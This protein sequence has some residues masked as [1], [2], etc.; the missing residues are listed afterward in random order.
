MQALRRKTMGAIIGASM[1]LAP[2][3]AMGVSVD[4]AEVSTAPAMKPIRIDVA[5]AHRLET[6]L[7]SGGEF[8]I[9]TYRTS[10]AGS[11]A[12]SDVLRWDN[13]F[14]YERNDYGIDANDD[15][16]ANLMSFRSI[17]FYGMSSDWTLFGGGLLRLAAESGADQGDGISAGGIAGFI[18]KCSPTLSVGLGIAVLSDIE[19]D[20][21]IAP[22]PIVEWAF[23][24]GWHLHVGATQYG[25][26][27][28]LGGG[29]STMITDSLELTAGAQYERRRFRL[30][31]RV[32]K[33]DEGV[34]EETS[35]PLYLQASW[36]FSEMASIDVFGG[37]AVGGT[38]TIDDEDGD[39]ISE[40][41]F[42]PTGTFG[43]RLNIRF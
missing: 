28:G 27:N 5:Y 42:D 23:A 20:V 32:G 31:E 36:A 38:L 19:D 14:V 22:L 30:D 29:V 12:L 16:D 26:R 24:Q 8:D 18:H 35:I 7:D 39:E 4:V 2:A 37:V 25:A 17:L 6:E 15:F 3:T 33:L 21:T 40:D 1:A 43:A 11:M 13:G 34:A 9:N 10:I 41:D